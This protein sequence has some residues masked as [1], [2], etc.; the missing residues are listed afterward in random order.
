[1]KTILHFTKLSILLFSYAILLSIASCKTA[2]IE[3]ND[4]EYDLLKKGYRKVTMKE[5]KSAVQVYTRILEINPENP[6]ALAYRGLCKYHLKDF[7]GA[8]I[9]F[10]RAILQQPDYAEA[11][12]L[13]GVVKGELG[14]K[15]GA[16][17]DWK[18]AFE[19]GFNDAFQLI[20]EF[21][22]EE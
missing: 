10:N 13:R 4:T 11:Y 21:C 22:W 3:G 8:L 15:E 16:C 19:L 9:D 1:M 20:K 7:E 6:E 14:D 17:S 2:S 12:D 5:Y 18:K